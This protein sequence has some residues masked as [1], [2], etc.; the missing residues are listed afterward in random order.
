MRQQRGLGL[1]GYLIGAAVVGALVIGALI[2][3]NK[4]I[5]DT[6]VRPAEIRGADRQRIADGLILEQVKS[7]R[8]NARADTA[9]CVAT[10][11]T[12]SDEVERWRQTAQANATLA[13]A[14]KAKAKRDASEAAPKIAE[15]QAKAAAAPVL[16]ACEQERDLARAALRDELRRRRGAEP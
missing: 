10:S 9:A 15:L 11:K 6:W 4:F 1:I 13:A 3:I 5:D 7:E 14:L 2:W 8:D 12:Q 16:M